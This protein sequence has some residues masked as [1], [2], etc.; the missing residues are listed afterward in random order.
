MLR[1]F[2]TTE[3]RAIDGNCHERVE[4]QRD[5]NHEQRDDVDDEYFWNHDPH[6]EQ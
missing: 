4:E 1:R 6:D 2:A 5:E 3:L